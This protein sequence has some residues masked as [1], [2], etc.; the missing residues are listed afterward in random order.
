MQSPGKPNRPSWKLTVLLIGL[1]IVTFAV[2]AWSPWYSLN[3]PWAGVVWLAYV[4]LAIRLSSLP[5]ILMLIGMCMGG[6]LPPV[7]HGQSGEAI[8]MESGT[9]FQAGCIGLLIGCIPSLCAAAYARFMG[10]AFEE[11]ARKTGTEGPPQSATE[12]DR[13][14]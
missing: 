10:L 6:M 3:N 13:L 1:P 12:V 9:A 2:Y 8:I 5:I 4:L 14:A 7:T 11:N